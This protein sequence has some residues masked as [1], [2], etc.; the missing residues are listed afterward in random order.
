V[1][2]EIKGERRVLTGNAAA[3]YGA[4]LSRPDVV[5][6]YPITPQTEVVELLAQFHANGMLD[7]EMI[8]VEG[9]N[10]AMSSIVAASVA[11]GRV[12]TATSS[13][14]LAFM[15][16][17]V[18]MAA[19]MRVPAVM[20][21]V[22][23]ETPGIYSVSCSRQDMMSVRD[24]GWI[25]IE[26]ET[27]QEIL[28]TVVMAYRLAEDSEILLPVMVSYDGYY[29]SFMSEDMEIPP[30]E[31]VDRFLAPLKDQ[32][33]RLKLV[34]GGPLGF[35][36]HALLEDFMEYRYKH[37]SAL[38]RTKDKLVQIEK[39]FEDIF[40]RSYH[41]AVE[42]YRCEDA[43]IVLMTMGSSTG[44]AR[45]AVDKKREQGIKV[46]LVK[47]RLFRPF[48]KDIV[49]KVLKGKKGVG[50]IDRSI[51]FGWNCGHMYMEIKSALYD[52]DQKVK[53]VNYI[54]GIASLDITIEHLERAVDEVHAASQGREC[55]DVTWLPL[56]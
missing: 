49:A 28:D 16:D 13:W 20:V 17:A 11:G 26:V 32:P 38:E 54:T 6:L 3:A 9:E 14:G 1:S 39:E 34:P 29:L 7:A 25:Q 19:G 33:E 24:A 10:S 30:Q 48:P 2:A 35:H 46:G 43:D 55:R 45:V 27:T 51:C 40:G 12:F 5:A 4:L 56:E 37:C 31:Y 15:Y 52:L 44:T 41:G 47:L 53:L 23:R 8:Q 18:L 42:Q 22:N 36:A 21:N 50:V